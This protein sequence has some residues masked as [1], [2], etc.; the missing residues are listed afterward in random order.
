MTGRLV[1]LVI[2]MGMWCAWPAGAQ[3]GRDRVLVVVDRSSPLAP[4]AAQAWAEKVLFA[5][6]EHLSLAVTTFQHGLGDMTAP[7]P[8]L[9]AA[10]SA[11]APQANGAAGFDPEPLVAQLQT[12]PDAGR[13]AMVLLIVGGDPA[14]LNLGKDRAWLQDGR[15]AELAAEYGDWQQAQ[16]T[17]K[18]LQEYFVPYYAQRQMALLADD[19]RGLS[20][21]LQNQMV[22][23]D[24]SGSAVQMRSWALSS[25]IRYVGKAVGDPSQIAP[26]MDAMRWETQRALNNA[27]ALTRTGGAWAGVIVLAV[28]IAAGMGGIWWWRRRPVPMPQAYNPNDFFLAEPE[29]PPPPP[30]PPGPVEFE[31][32]MA[33]G[34]LQVF[35]RDGQA[36]RRQSH[37]R[38]LTMEGVE[39]QPEQGTPIMVEEIRSP[40]LDISIPLNR[41]DITA[42]EAGIWWAAFGE[43]PGGI[44]DRM[45]LLD[46]VTEIGEG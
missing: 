16:A 2:L 17:A 42:K 1:A 4:L 41:C 5:R 3:E 8:D 18:E 6:P 23:W 45:K 46:L 22:V 36:Q 25:Q 28:G 12:L 33:P 20:R 10:L 35:W 9:A 14:P 31:T 24:L 40:A 30:P 7:A 27:G 38:C 44:D 37:G 19:A 21:S 26:A 39:F 34:M 29:P 11:L 32:H 43:F 13:W 15:Y